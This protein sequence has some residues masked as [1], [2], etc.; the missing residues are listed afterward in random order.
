MTGIDT[1]TRIPCNKYGFN[2]LTPFCVWYIHRKSIVKIVTANR[3]VPRFRIRT[4]MVMVAI[5]SC[6]FAVGHKARRIHCAAELIEANGGNV[7][8]GETLYSGQRLGTQTRTPTQLLVDRT[9]I[10]VNLFRGE[11]T[12]LWVCFIPEDRQSFVRTIETLRPKSISFDVLGANDRA[13]LLKR[14]AKIKIGN[15]DRKAPEEK[16]HALDEVAQRTT[17]RGSTADMTRQDNFTRTIEMV[18]RMLAENPRL[19]YR[20]E[21]YEPIIGYPNHGEMSRLLDRDTGRIIYLPWPK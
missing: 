3:F 16:H 21:R 1:N 14:F 4:L 15:A 13:W 8:L 11:E 17:N 20:L 10:V 18:E 6:L 2:A 9:Q 12:D 7:W 19:A 5:M